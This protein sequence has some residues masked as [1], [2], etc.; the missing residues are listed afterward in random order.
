MNESLVAMPIKLVS[1]RLKCKWLYS[2]LQSSINWTFQSEVQTDIGTSSF[3]DEILRAAFGETGAR[4]GTGLI[5]AICNRRF[6]KLYSEN[7]LLTGEMA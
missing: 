4:L 1:S 3:K 6:L 2:R 5:D 7:C